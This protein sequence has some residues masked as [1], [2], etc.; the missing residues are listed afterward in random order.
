MLPVSGRVSRATGP[1]AGQVRLHFRLAACLAAWTANGNA[2]KPMAANSAHFRSCWR[3]SSLWH[4]PSIHDNCSQLSRCAHRVISNMRS[5]P[6]VFSLV[7]NPGSQD[8]GALLLPA[9]RPKLVC[10]VRNLCSCRCCCADSP[11]RLHMPPVLPCAQ[12]ELCCSTCD[13][14]VEEPWCCLRA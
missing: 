7:H 5:W 8:P 4:Y 13:R 6:E 10:E 11:L 2:N 9:H 3:C 1:A 14:A 12:T